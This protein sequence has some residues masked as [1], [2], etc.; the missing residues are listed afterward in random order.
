MTYSGIFSVNL[1]AHVLLVYFQYI[2]VLGKI[3]LKVNEWVNLV[4]KTI[5]YIFK[6]NYHP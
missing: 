5:N 2:K 3:I 4:S 1:H 6:T